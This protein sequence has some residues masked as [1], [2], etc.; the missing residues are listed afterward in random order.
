MGEKLVIVII[1]GMISLFGND[2][3][4]NLQRAFQERY[5][6]AV[7][8]LEKR[9]YWFWHFAFMRDYAGEIAE[10][11]KGRRVMLVGH[12]LGG[13][14]GL[15]AA[16]KMDNVHGVITIFSPYNAYCGIFR[17]KVIGP[18]PYKVLPTISFSASRD[19]YFKFAPRGTR[20]PHAIHHVEHETDH[21]FELTTSVALADNIAG[22][23]QL[24]L[25]EPDR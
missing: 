15:S 20:H 4:P 16:Q 3:L 19:I 2:P 12:S 23:V 13:T 22:Y 11:Y 6:R 5:P 25:P 14:I 18:G 21:I 10:K 7:I 9:D 8:V 1:H 17:K 24:F